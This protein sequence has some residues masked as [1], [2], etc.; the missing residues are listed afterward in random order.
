[1]ETMTRVLVA[2][3]D[4]A[5]KQMCRRALKN[6]GCAVEYSSGGFD[7]LSILRKRQYDILAVA[8]SLTDMGLIELLLNI[9]EIAPDELTIVVGGYELWRFRAILNRCNVT[10]SGPVEEVPQMV[11]KAVRDIHAVST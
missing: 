2:T 8:D 1:M 7:I 3:A 6:C 9:R 10:L 11:V 4:E 5:V